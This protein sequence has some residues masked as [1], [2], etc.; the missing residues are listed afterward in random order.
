[1][2]AQIFGM[3]DEVAEQFKKLYPEVIEAMDK[4]NFDYTDLVFIRTLSNTGISTA[5]PRFS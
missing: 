3:A 2:F 1:M 5:V 4:T